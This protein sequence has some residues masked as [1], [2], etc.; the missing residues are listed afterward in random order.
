MDE[1]SSQKR[2]KAGSAKGDLSEAAPGILEKK[3]DDLGTKIER[4]AEHVKALQ[5]PQTEQKIVV[6]DAG[7]A[8]PEKKPEGAQQAKA[9]DVIY[10]KKST[11]FSFYS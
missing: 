1:G 5:A 11:E 4:L 3:I 10:V 8:E 2:S 6:G 7:T 9:Q